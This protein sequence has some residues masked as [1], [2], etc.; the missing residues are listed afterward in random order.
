MHTHEHRARNVNFV[1]IRARNNNSNGNRNCNIF[2]YST[3]I[4]VH[5]GLGMNFYSSWLVPMRARACVCVVAFGWCKVS[6]WTALPF[7]HVCMTYSHRDGM[8][9]SV[10]ICNVDKCLDR[11]YFFFVN[12]I[13][14]SWFFS[15][16]FGAF[17][18][19]GQYQIYCSNFSTNNKKKSSIDTH[20]TNLTNVPLPL[21]FAAAAVLADYFTDRCCTL[22]SCKSNRQPA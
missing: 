9:W 21:L 8:Y 22:S 11:K 10:G 7:D 4:S 14:W 5:L 16:E 1:A 20:F 6:R 15:G 18:S 12:E 3:S 13:D 2:K 19:L 17:Q